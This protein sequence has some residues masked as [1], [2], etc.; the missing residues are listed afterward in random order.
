MPAPTAASAAATSAPTAPAASQATVAPAVEPTVA[1]TPEPTLF[2]PD[3]HAGRSG[4]GRGGGRGLPSL[5]RRHGAGAV[6]RRSH[7]SGRGCRGP[8]AFRSGA[9]N[10]RQPGPG[11]VASSLAARLGGFIDGPR[12]LARSAL[13]DQ[14]GHARSRDGAFSGRAVRGAR[15]RLPV[16]RPH[17]GPPET[18]A[19]RV[20][21]QIDLTQR[22]PPWP[23]SLASLEAPRDRAQP[24]YALRPPESCAGL[25][26]QL[27]AGACMM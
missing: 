26:G 23:H 2:D 11:E 4:Y 13:E 27:R 24:G 20:K 15:G 18:D 5:F 6:H 25:E 19:A 21:R 8:A 7:R 9:D 17:P 14:M 1:A 12:P 10:R 22:N 3:R 16:R